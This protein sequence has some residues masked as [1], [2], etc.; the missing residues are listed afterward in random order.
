M[1]KTEKGWLDNWDGILKIVNFWLVLWVNLFQYKTDCKDNKVSK[2]SKVSKDRGKAKGQG[3]GARRSDKGTKDKV[4]RSKG[5][6][7]SSC[8]LEF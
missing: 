5:T 3:E 2:V 8:F 4:Q 1:T 7:L 6:R